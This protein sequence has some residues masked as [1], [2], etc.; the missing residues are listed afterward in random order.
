MKFLV[1]SCAD[2][3]RRHS[4]QLKFELYKTADQIEQVDGYNSIHTFLASRD[5]N[6]RLA[7]KLREI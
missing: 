4:R 5:S 7:T 2:S 1:S 6:M 3:R